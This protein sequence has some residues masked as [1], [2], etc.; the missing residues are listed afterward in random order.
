MHSPVMY[1][2]LAEG[3]NPFAGTI[4]QAVAAVIV[5][6]ALLVILRKMAWGPI[7]TGLQDREN[8]IKS[9]LESAE[10]AAGDADATLQDYK[11]KLAA[12]QEEARTIIEASRVEAERLAAQLKDQTHSEIKQIKDKA[13]RDIEAAKQQ[14]VT[15]L[16][17]QAAAVSTQ[18][19][20]RILK[21]ELNAADQQS[22]VDESL[23]QL[24]AQNN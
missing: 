24:K 5:F 21:R 14:A 3:D 8:R 22:I 10:K 11:A 23:A 15:E 1:L 19:A 9:D 18:I 7:L 16:Y 4:Y 13:T 20:G 2:V 17:A 12:A 6:V